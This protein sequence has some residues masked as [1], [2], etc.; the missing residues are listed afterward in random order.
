VTEPDIHAQ[1]QQ[2]LAQEAN[3]GLG[4]IELRA[5]AALSPFSRAQMAAATNLLTK[6][7]RALDDDDI[8][9]AR[10]FVDRAVALPYDDHERRHPGAA[11]AH[12]EMF[13][14]VTDALEDGDDDWLGAAADTLTS[15]PAEARYSMR[16]TLTAILQDY[17]LSEHE[18]RR[19]RHLIKD[20]PE[21][22]ELGDLDL[23][24]EQ[25]AAAV[26]EVLEGVIHFEDSML[27][28][29]NLTHHQE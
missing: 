18:Q 20:I 9:R 7:L 13:S 14:V 27:E 24:P 28:H 5:T 19:V 16:D 17:D 10:R 21:R 29:H 11:M 8:D 3:R 6:A 25:M 22:V 1:F 23:P 2:Y 12:M 4:D 26:L 15:A